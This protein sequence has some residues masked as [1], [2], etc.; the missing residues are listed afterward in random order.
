MKAVQR[1]R[2]YCDFC[3]KAGQSGYHMKNHERSCTLNPS[4][5]C[6]MCGLIEGG[7][8]A[9]LQAMMSLLPDPALFMHMVKF[10]SE[11]V[12]NDDAIKLLI[13]AALP[14]MRE[15]CGN[16]PVCI[17]AALR[18]KKIPVPLA[19]GFDYKEE[20]K[21]HFQDINDSREHSY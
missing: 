1:W 19:E 10:C 21:S 13:A 8:G 20:M 11:P 5:V 16:C 18:Q 12:L 4:R 9:D 17:L 2:Y 14:A 3:T 15:L 7:N 6:K